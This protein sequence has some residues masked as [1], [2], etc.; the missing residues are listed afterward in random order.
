MRRWI[1]RILVILFVLVLVAAATATIIL[2]TDLPRRWTTRILSQQLSM[3]ITADSLHAGMWGKTTVRDFT[4]SLPMDK[5]PCL[6]I[7]EI[8]ISHSPLPLILLGASAK[9][10]SLRIVNPTANVRQDENGRWNVLELASCL[11]QFVS[12]HDERRNV[13]LPELD[14]VNGASVVTNRS[15]LVENIGPFRFHGTPQDSGRWDFEMNISPN[16]A[17]SGKVAAGSDWAHEINFDIKDVNAI[18]GSLLPDISEALCMSGTLSGH[19]RKSELT[20]KLKLDSV[21]YGKTQIQGILGVNVSPTGLLVQFEDLL[22]RGL[23]SPAKAFRIAGG[24]AR[25]DGKELQVDHVGMDA[26]SISANFAGNWN[27]MRADGRLSGSW[28]GKST[29]RGIYLEGTWDGSVRWP[30]MG[31]KEVGVSVFTRGDCPWGDWQST[32]EILGSGS[33]LSKSKWQVSVPRLSCRIR[34]NNIALEDVRAEVAADWPAVRLVS[35]HSANPGTLKAEGEFLADK[36]SW[37]ISVEAEKWKA[38]GRQD[39]T[40]DLRLAATGNKQDVTVKE[41]RVAQKDIRLEATG[42]VMLPSTELRDAYAK[43]SWVVHPPP[44]DPEQLAAI[45]G[46]LQCEA[47]ISGTVRPLRLQLKSELLGENVTLNRKVISAVKIPLQAQID[48]ERIEYEAE[49][50]GLFGGN[51]NV[52]G[53][54]EFHQP[55]RKAT[56]NASEV[57]LKPMVEL[58]G[59]PLKS[60]GLMAVKLQA[61]LP[62]YNI[63]DLTLA[64]SWQI[65]DMILGTVEA[66]RADGDVRIEN[67]VAMFDRIHLERSQGRVSASARFDLNRPQYVSVDME[68]RQ[69]PLDL[70]DHNMTLVTDG[71][72]NATLDLLKRTAEGQGNLSAVVAVNAKTLGDLSAEIAFRKRTIDIND[73]TIE[74]LGGSVDATARIHLDNWP[75][76]KAEAKWHGLNIAA[77]ADWRP[78][79][80]DFAGTSSGV[81]TVVQADGKRPLEPM[82]LD[83]RADISDGIFRNVQFGDFQVSGY[84]GKERL[85]IDRSQIAILDGSLN[86]QGSFRRQSDGLLTHVRADFSQLE[87]D[88]LVHFF[89]KG[90]KRVPGRLAGGG[91]LIVSS[92]F[93]RM[94]GEA[95]LQLSESDLANTIIAGTLYDTMN[96]RFGQTEPKGEGQM[97]L[98]FEGSAVRIPSFTYFNRGIE[99]RGMGVIDDLAQGRTSPVSGYAIGSVRP[100][101][102]TNLPGMDDLDRLMT[103]LQT[104]V[105]S[106]RI[107]GTLAE[108]EVVPVPLPEISEVLRVLL[109]RQRRK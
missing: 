43:A 31:R 45:S 57:S 96:A 65:R 40:V 41:F 64:G 97:K 56:L 27:W 47:A 10:R 98:R 61:E 34:N 4:L 80:K 107:G 59:L 93:D 32:M 38:I 109:W 23:D 28:A 42:K 52:S 7:E 81:L 102:G 86:A 19:A 83:I 25:L 84:I 73:M 50:F 71:K 30:H 63:D 16:V 49:R 35:L 92:G 101:K 2:R 58:L 99:I 1:L 75:A 51:W 89:R 87:I 66:E 8:H 18:A 21:Q 91:V 22:V 95:A 67:G 94:T 26:G 53:T 3:K 36:S 39:L 90:E 88:Q 78:E 15:G 100:L 70:P 69:W 74:A 20:G 106:V 68:A 14:I 108:P 6:A 37:A 11:G 54:Y 44:A 79:L 48:T 46:R 72:G 104:G 82:R 105:A 9:L 24:S 85:V 62:S 55:S 33:T 12:G 60:K 17:V 76:S 5:G 13:R 77:L 103:S 29:E